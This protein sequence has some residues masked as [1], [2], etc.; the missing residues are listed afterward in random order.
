[1]VILLLAGVAWAGPP[2]APDPASA[3]PVTVT[4]RGHA[5]R[6][7]GACGDVPVLRVASTDSTFRDRSEA[8]GPVILVTDQSVDPT[9]ADGWPAPA[10]NLYL[11]VVVPLD[12]EPARAHLVRGLEA[13]RSARAPEWTW[14]VGWDGP[15]GAHRDASGRL[16][17]GLALEP[18]PGGAT[19]L[20][21]DVHLSASQA[22]YGS[23]GAA[24]GHA[25]LAEA[26]GAPVPVEP[27]LWDLLGRLWVAPEPAPTP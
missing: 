11:S 27:E 8:A 6:R 20:G 25:T 15:Y 17:T 9:S 16:V 13:W 23:L 10:G 3:A 2:C 21:V 7:I 5:Y 19:A 4:L 22:D 14:T 1:M 26:R 12:V 24:G 18:R